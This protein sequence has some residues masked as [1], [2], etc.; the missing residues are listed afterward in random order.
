MFGVEG[1]GT[2]EPRLK[3][4]TTKIMLQLCFGNIKLRVWN[5]EATMIGVLDAATSTALQ[6]GGGEGL[7][8]QLHLNIGRQ[9]CEP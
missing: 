3:V 6:R 5:E 2:E 7:K 8:N 1:R 9:V 4:K